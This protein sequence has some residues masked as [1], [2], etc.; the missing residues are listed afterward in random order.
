ML[1]NSQPEI[2]HTI[3][4]ATD[5]NSTTFAFSHFVFIPKD[6]SPW[7]MKRYS[8]VKMLLLKILF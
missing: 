2:Y 3:P 1:S 5:K 4:I 7:Q 8:C 6:A